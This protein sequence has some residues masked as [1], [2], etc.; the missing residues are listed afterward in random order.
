MN[1]PESA[2]ASVLSVKNLDE[3][4]QAIESIDTVKVC[5]GGTKPAL[6][7]SANLCLS[8]M[9]GILQYDPSEY[10]FTALAGTKLSD[11]RKMLSEYGQF[12]PFDP[13]LV[14]AG[15]TLGGTVAAGVSGSGRYRYG[16]V[17]DFLLGVQLVTLNNRV[18]FGGG[19]VVKNAAG[20]DIP[21]LMVGS[22]GRLGVMTELTFKVFPRPSVYTTL[23]L[24]HS[25]FVAALH[26]LSDLVRQPMDLICLDLDP[27]E[28]TIAV[29]IGGMGESVAQRAAKIRGRADSSATEFSS[30]D[31]SQYWCEVNE[32]RWL[33]SGDRLVKIPL[34]PSQLPAAEK[35]I[36]GWGESFSRRYAVGGNLLWLGWP[37]TES[38]V[39][40][41][42]LCQQ[43]DTTGL[44]VTGSWTDEGIGRPDGV[45]FENRI[46]ASFRTR[47]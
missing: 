35:L 45:E 27:N 18:V 21:K 29:R 4:R 2:N 25:S 5:A 7:T 30:D 41:Q 15:A 12:M 39:K 44:A 10:T 20:F 1:K 22:L 37:Q 47:S 28:Y 11:V 9:S 36:S 42:D 6:S 8:A 31:D 34:T 32:F 16:G 3:L 13:P 40:L 19:K 23:L 17:R 33:H 14:E 38:S 43:L 26:S 46:A 24:R